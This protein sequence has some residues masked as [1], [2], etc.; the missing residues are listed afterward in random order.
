MAVRHCDNDF[1]AKRIKAW[2]DDVTK[3]RVDEAGLFERIY[4]D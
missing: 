2:V 3:G 1:L 4:E